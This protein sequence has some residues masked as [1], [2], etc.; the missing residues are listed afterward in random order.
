M[1]ASGAGPTDGIGSAGGTGSAGG[2]VGQLA[3][4][5]M[6]FGRVLRAAGMAVGTDRV[7]LA[8]QALPLAGLERREDF[9][10]VLQACLLD[11]HEHEALFDQAFALFWRDGEPNGL[12]EMTQR[13]EPP[14]ARLKGPERDRK[15]VV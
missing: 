1:H 6:H 5:V 2:G 15:S 13:A 8:L 7:Q 4:N 12:A 3:D 9:H 14:S 10:A 11:R